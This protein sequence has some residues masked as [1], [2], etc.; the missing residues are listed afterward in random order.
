MARTTT[1]HSVARAGA[2]RNAKRGCRAMSRR[3]METTCATIFPLPRPEAGMRCPH[4]AATLRSPVTASSRPRMIITIQVSTATPN[5]AMPSVSP[6]SVRERVSSTTTST[7]TRKM[8]RTVR[9]LGRFT[10]GASDLDDLRGADALGGVPRV[11]DDGGRVHDL[12]V[13]IGAVVGHDHHEIGGAHGRDQVLRAHHA[14]TVVE[15]QLR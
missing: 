10:P 11:H 3:K 6:T 15:M 13:Q 1:S 2:C 7:G 5:I 14:L 8:R 12:A 4:P 9:A